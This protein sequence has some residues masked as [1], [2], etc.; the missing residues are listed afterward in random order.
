LYLRRSCGVGSVC[1]DQFMFVKD[2][3][4][5]DFYLQSAASR[6]LPRSLRVPKNIEEINLYLRM[7]AVF[8]HQRFDCLQI[9]RKI[10][11]LGLPAIH[12]INF[13]EKSL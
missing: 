6:Q 8:L 2:G 7:R 4:K 3:R 9:D 12:D 13:H 5:I 1:K 11:W 10:V